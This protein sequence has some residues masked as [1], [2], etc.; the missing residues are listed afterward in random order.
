[1]AEVKMVLEGF[2]ATCASIFLSMKQT[3]CEMSIDLLGNQAD[4]MIRWKEV[5]GTFLNLFFIMLISQ[6][7]RDRVD[8]YLLLC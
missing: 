7:S 8:D 2:C 5:S 1:M 4:V 6:T 3:S